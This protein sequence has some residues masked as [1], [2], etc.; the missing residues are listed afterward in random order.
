MSLRGRDQ[1]VAALR[2]AEAGVRQ[3]QAQRAI[4]EEQ[5]R[6]V[7]VGRGGLEAVAVTADVKLVAVGGQNRV[8]YLLDASS[9]EVKKRFYV[10]ARVGNLAFS[11]DGK[12]L[13]VGGAGA[14]HLFD[15][16]R[17]AD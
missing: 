14:T 3:A 5:V 6:T 1:T 7:T 11:K 12:R 2:Q 10:G 4:A 15:L 13:A 17:K 8:V 9:L 16:T